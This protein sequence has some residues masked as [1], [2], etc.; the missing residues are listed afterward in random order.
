MQYVLWYQE[1]GS[2]ILVW[3]CKTVS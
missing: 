3:W 2:V 1:M